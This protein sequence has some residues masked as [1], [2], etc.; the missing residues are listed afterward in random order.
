[1]TA[2]ESLANIVCRSANARLVRVEFATKEYP[3]RIYFCANVPGEPPVES[4]P[5]ADFN[6][7]NVRAALHQYRIEKLE[8][9]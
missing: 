2:L 6:S 8:A 4:L 5:I 3:T 9:Q 7:R 1:M